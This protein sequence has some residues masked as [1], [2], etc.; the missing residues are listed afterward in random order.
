MRFDAA[1]VIALA[2]PFASAQEPTSI[3]QVKT[4]IMRFDA[5]PNTS[6][7]VLTELEARLPKIGIAVTADPA[8][9]DAELTMT[10]IQSSAGSPFT[11][12]VFGGVKADV[13][14]TVRVFSLPSHRLLFSTMQGAQDDELSDACEK[15]A[16]S[17]IKSLKKARGRS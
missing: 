9:A 5:E 8:E 13:S 3:T 17:V 1:V 10:S 2:M 7:M 4:I 14:S 11:G 6:T 15:T 12:G 16:K